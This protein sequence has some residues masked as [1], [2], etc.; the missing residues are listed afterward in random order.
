MR[1]IDWNDLKLFLAVA[2]TGSLNKAARRLGVNH[3][4]V[5]R[6]IAAFEARLGGKLFERSAKGYALTEAAESLIASVRTM[7][8]AA[9]DIERAIIGSDIGLT[10]VIRVTTTD[11]LAVTLIP[12]LLAQFSAAHPSVTVEL[13]TTSAFANLTKREADIA[14]RPSLTVSD[15]LV[16][17]NVGPIAFL[18][19]ARLRDAGRIRDTLADNVAAQWMNRNIPNE[20]VALRVDSFVVARELIS[21][22]VG[23]GFLPR[24]LGSGN[25]AIKPVTANQPAIASELWILTHADLARSA[26]VRAFTT[27]A[28]EFLKSQRAAF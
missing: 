5:L 7:E 26:R 22:G 2:D 28:F 1:G 20:R 17:R 21:E 10:G 11:T 6:R 16:G 3:T 23:I 13:S 14:I 27:L 19:Y 15:S 25:R 18:A 24:Y 4:T 9:H 8:D 12:A